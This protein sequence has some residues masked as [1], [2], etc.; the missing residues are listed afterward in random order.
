MEPHIE[1][2]EINQVID[3]TISLLENYART[4]NIDIQTHLASDLPIIA[5]DQA[6]LQQVFLNLV[7]NAIDAIGNGGSIE[8]STRQLDGNIYVNVKDDGPGMTPD[9]QKKIFEPFVTTKSGGKGTGLGL[10]VSLGI[11]EK[12]GGTITVESKVGKGS[13]FTVK[14]PIVV[15]EKK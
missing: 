12:M 14:L 1:D 6:Q 9:M 13:T 15:P 7:S 10:W 2:V 11:V 4:S 3:Q 8:V 5:S